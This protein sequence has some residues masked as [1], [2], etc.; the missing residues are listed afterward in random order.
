VFAVVDAD[1][2]QIEDPKNRTRHH[3]DNAALIRLFNG[4]DNHL[5]P[6]TTCWLS[7]FVMGPSNLGD[8]VKGEFIE[9][10]G[11][12]GVE[13]FE[14][15][16]N[17]ASIECGNAGGLEKNAVYIGNLLE[18]LKEAKVTSK[19]LDRLCEMIIAFKN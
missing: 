3:R 11:V 9:A 10:L 8:T 4:D 6:V 5:F 12:Q 16:R 19:S 14:D 18:L 1:G 17:Q 2:D 13:Q 15:M 7:N